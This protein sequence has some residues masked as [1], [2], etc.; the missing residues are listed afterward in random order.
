MRGRCKPGLELEFRVGS[1][2]GWVM[3]IGS[4]VGLYPGT[5]L[6]VGYVTIVDSRVLLVNGIP[7]FFHI[8]T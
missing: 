5:G 2:K 8:T 7:F 3:G 1:C 4:G 6:G